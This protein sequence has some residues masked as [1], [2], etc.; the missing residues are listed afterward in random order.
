MPVLAAGLQRVQVAKGWLT[1]PS[2]TFE[3][4][5]PSGGL[6]PWLSALRVLKRSGLERHRAPLL[7]DVCSR[8]ARQSSADVLQWSVGHSHPISSPSL[9]QVGG[10]DLCWGPMAFPVFPAPLLISFAYKYFPYK[11]LAHSILSWSLL[12]RISWLRPC[13]RPEQI[14]NRAFRAWW[15]LPRGAWERFSQR[16]FFKGS[17]SQLQTRFRDRG[18][19]GTSPRPGC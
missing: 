8:M 11:I 9:L 13:Y 2:V 19:N 5:P 14:W 10:G 6:T 18:K 12:F 15:W 1:S 4:T 17:S 7:G 3:V 16:G